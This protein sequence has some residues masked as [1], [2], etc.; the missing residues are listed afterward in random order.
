MTRKAPGM[1]EAEW[2]AQVV[3]L[4]EL[5]GWGWAHFRPARTARGWRTPVSGPMGAGWPDL[6]LV[7]DR[8]LLVE[9][10]RIGGKPRPDQVAVLEAFRAAGAEVYVWTPAD[11]DEAARVLAR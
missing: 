5:Y 4:A 2:Q 8:I 6:V 9:L 7:R 10:K 11:F 1:L 3:Q